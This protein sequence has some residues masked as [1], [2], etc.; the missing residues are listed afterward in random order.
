MR[1]LSV[2][3]HPLRDQGI[4]GGCVV[5]VTV[6]GWEFVRTGDDDGWVVT[7]VEFFKVGKGGMNQADVDAVMAD[8]K[9]SETSEGCGKYEVNLIVVCDKVLDRGAGNGEW[10]GP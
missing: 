6:D 1:Q 10:Q 9:C 5:I 2:P 4:A 8:V 7:D 3:L